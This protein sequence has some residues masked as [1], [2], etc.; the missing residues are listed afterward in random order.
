MKRSFLFLVSLLALVRSVFSQEIS[1]QEADSMINALSKSKDDA[2]VE[3][4]LNLAQFHIFKP[5]ENRIDL[6]S[7]TIYIDEAK[8]LARSSKSHDLDGYVQLTEACLTK[9]KG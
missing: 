2:R 8:Q 7:A 6:D 9:E 4:L 3:L 1:R 5:G